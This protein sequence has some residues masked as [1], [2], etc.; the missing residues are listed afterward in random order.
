MN[1]KTA[2]QIILL[3]IVIALTSLF[4]S[5]YV[6]I[7]VLKENVNQVD[8]SNSKLD[9]INK[10][11]TLKD[12]YYESY[13]QNGNKFIIK[14]KF[15][16]FEDED[17]Q[18]ILMTNVKA[19]IEIKDSKNIYLVSKMARYNILSNNT[20]F[21]NEVELIYQDNQINCENLDISFDNNEIEAYNDLTYKN[22][23]TTLMADK[24]MI[25]FLTKDSK[26][27]MMDESNVKIMVNN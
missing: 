15:G 12:I 26:I 16:N 9:E 5:K 17:Q 19:V 23:N 27:Y 4:Y 18:I 6:N 1:Y 13:D 20:N 24:V 21:F 10:L 25:N 14:S 2:T 22:T 3:L 7:N 11:D 8:E